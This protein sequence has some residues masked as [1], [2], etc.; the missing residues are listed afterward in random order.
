MAQLLITIDRNRTE[1]EVLSAAKAQSLHR[2]V[3]CFGKHV[4][5]LKKQQR[6]SD[7]GAV[8]RPQALT[9]VS[10]VNVEKFAAKNVKREQL[11][12]T[13]SVRSMAVAFFILIKTKF[14]MQIVPLAGYKRCASE[15]VAKIN[16]TKKHSFGL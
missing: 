14:S 2:S 6:S 8:F 7:F 3:N 11:E 15:S 13:F 9:S 1:G 4:T 10:T 16:L 12:E 5:E